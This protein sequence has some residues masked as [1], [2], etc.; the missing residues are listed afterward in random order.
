LL[1]VPGMGYWYLLAWGL[2][3]CGL[4]ASLYGLHRLGLWLEDRGWLYYC[5]K[6]PTSSPMSAGVA[7]HQFIEPGVRHVI[8][9]KHGEFEQDREVARERLLARLL[10]CLACLDG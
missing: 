1:E 8:T 7:L 9:T 2:A 10:A 6:K 5:R 4:A 3:L